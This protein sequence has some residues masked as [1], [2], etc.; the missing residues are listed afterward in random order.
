M[1]HIAELLPPDYQGE[2]RERVASREREA[3]ELAR[4]ERA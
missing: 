3:A 1:L 2:F 4:A